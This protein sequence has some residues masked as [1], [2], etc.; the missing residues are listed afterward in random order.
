MTDT[1]TTRASD[2]PPSG[3]ESYMTGGD[4]ATT[5]SEA[6]DDQGANQRYMDGV[7]RDTRQRGSFMD[8][9]V[10]VAMQEAI[11]ASL[12]DARA[13]LG[14]G[15]S[16]QHLAHAPIEGEAEE[17]DTYQVE[18]VDMAEAQRRRNIKLGKRPMPPPKEQD[19]TTEAA[20]TMHAKRSRPDRLATGFMADARRGM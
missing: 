9:T 10:D 1:G 12:A 8:G 7:E 18:D 20:P 5:S 13:G 17:A 19:D 14:A 2:G 15:P 6:G 3:E 16:G 11:A 4:D